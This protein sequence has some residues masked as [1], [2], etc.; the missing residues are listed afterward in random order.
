MRPDAPRDQVDEALE[1]LCRM[2][3][4]IE[5]VTYWSVGRDV[6][7]DFDYGA[8]FAVEDIEG[9]RAYMHA[10]LHRRV[11]EIGLPLVRRMVSHDLT[12][13]E[14]PATGDLIRQIHAERFAGDPALVALIQGL[15]SYEG[16]SAP[17]PDRS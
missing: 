1:M 3:R 12:D 16:S 6:G 15:G 5:A 11:D 7:G 17:E 8:L 10:P 9:Y 2:G 4:E 14:D 13:D